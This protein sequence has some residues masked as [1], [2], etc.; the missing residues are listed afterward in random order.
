MMSQ[1]D[2]WKTACPPEYDE[3]TEA[4]PEVP[5]TLPCGRPDIDESA[6][7]ELESVWDCPIRIVGKEFVCSC[8]QAVTLMHTDEYP[9]YLRQRARR[10]G[11]PDPS[12][13]IIKLELNRPKIIAGGHPYMVIGEGALFTDCEVDLST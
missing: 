1:Y 8:G 4:E 11:H 13:Q 10:L 12:D 9:N 3:E 6:R 2:V 7:A 5:M